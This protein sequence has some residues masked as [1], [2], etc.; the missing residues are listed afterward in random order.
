ME[1]FDNN[2]KKII[3]H[4]ITNQNTT[5]NTSNLNPGVYIYSIANKSN[6]KIETGKWIKSD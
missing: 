2:G 6:T 3:S 1:L 4:E 5:I